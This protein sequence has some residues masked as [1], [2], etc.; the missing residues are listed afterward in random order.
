M[1][2]P[3]SWFSH[4]L[5]NLQLR[6]VAANK[7]LISFRVVSLMVGSSPALASLENSLKGIQLNVIGIAEENKPFKK[8]MYVYG[9]S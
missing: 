1:D 5:S 7:V 6:E 3:G 4:T 8:N 9:F 2:A